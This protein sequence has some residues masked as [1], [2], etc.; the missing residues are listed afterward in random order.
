MH[1]ITIKLL[2]AMYINKYINNS[3]YNHHHH[4]NI[5]IKAYIYIYI[6]IYI[7]V[8]VCVYVYLF[9]YASLYVWIYNI[10]IYI[11]LAI[12]YFEIDFELFSILPMTKNS[13]VYNVTVKTE[14]ETDRG[15]S[16]GMTMIVISIMVSF[17]IF[18]V[19]VLLDCTLKARKKL[20]FMV[21]WNY[22]HINYKWILLFRI[23]RHYK[24]IRK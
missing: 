16:F 15:N 3:Y 2:S 8:C 20:V 24:F 22:K 17:I 4:L 19:T 13:S 21:V 12:H 1:N 6:Y 10:I 18:M 11:T 5:R 14:Y 7:Y 9:L 23:F